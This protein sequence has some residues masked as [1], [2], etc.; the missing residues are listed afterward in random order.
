MYT[1]TLQTMNVTYVLT[2][3]SITVQT[4]VQAIL[5]SMLVFARFYMLRYG[6]L[7]LA[8]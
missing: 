7:V 1:D 2:K 6:K 5:Y 4:Y 3:A 8:I